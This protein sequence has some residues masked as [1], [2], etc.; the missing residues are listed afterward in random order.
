MFERI[1]GYFEDARENEEIFRSV[2][3]DI[4]R[5]IEYVPRDLDPTS[6]L[7]DLFRNY[8][9]TETEDGELQF[10]IIDFRK[11]P[12]TFRSINLECNEAI[13]G[14]QNIG[15][16]SGSGMIIKYS[17]NPDNSVEYKEII[18]TWAS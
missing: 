17:I 12:T 16:L 15:R 6:P 18:S 4:K 9:S 14:I 7:E 8:S 10:S 1:P 11:G 3:E 2:L 13:I 5:R